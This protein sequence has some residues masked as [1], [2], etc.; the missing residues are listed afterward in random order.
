MSQKVSW[1][2]AKFYLHDASGVD[3]PEE[4]LWEK[5]RDI[6]YPVKRPTKKYISKEMNSHP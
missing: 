1:L 3:N 2:I 4:Y 6:Y 5:I